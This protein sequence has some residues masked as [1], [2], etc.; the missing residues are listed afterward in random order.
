VGSRATTTKEQSRRQLFSFHFFRLSLSLSLSLSLFLFCEAKEINGEPAAGSAGLEV[1]EAAVTYLDG[2]DA[3]AAGLEEDAD[4]A[5][6]HALAQ[7]AHHAAGHQ[8]I[9]HVH[10]RRRS[11]TALAAGWLARA[12]AVFLGVRRMGEE[13]RKWPRF[14]VW[15]E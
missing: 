11:L 1:E 6:R 12:A 7:A 2:G 14:L 3:E 9:L 13:E 15:M 5:G 8:H 4:A 10:A